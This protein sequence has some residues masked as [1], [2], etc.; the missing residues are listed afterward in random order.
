M[1]VWI[2]RAAWAVC[3][4]LA[5]SES[6]AAEVIDLHTMVHVYGSGS[7]DPS[8]YF[9][10]TAK[11]ATSAALGP[12]TGSGAGN[13]SQWATASASTGAIAGQLIRGRATS[14]SDKP[15]SGFVPA[16]TA[17][18]SASW[19]DILYLKEP[20]AVPDPL[21]LRFEID[22]SLAITSYSS[23]SNAS[24]E[25]GFSLFSHVDDLLIDNVQTT[26]VHNRVKITRY[27]YNTE[28]TDIRGFTIHNNDPG[29]FVGTFEYLIP[30]N[31]E[32]G[33]Y[34]WNLVGMAR[35]ITYGASAD[36][37]FS[38]TLR[39]EG[40]YDQNGARLDE[41]MF[42]LDSGLTFSS[43]VPEP[44]SAVLAGLGVVALTGF[45]MRRGRAAAR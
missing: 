35:T 23:Y 12:A 37:D 38:H 11:G 31:P 32:Y 5:G 17:F 30:Y 26:G 39:L 4:V 43:A 18:A 9:D 34:T 20:A 27:G 45:L 15:D 6:L 10:S 14:F 7:G 41:S 22:G 2:R 36:A 24:A 25:F 13:G 19:R 21:M 40:V 3:V 8:I 1:M 44:S 16:G 29:A 33:G 42:R 28:I